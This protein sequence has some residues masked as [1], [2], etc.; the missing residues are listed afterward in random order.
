M[1]FL[2]RYPSKVPLI[3]ERFRREKY[4]GEIDKVKFEL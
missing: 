2:F 1:V 4:I 3:V